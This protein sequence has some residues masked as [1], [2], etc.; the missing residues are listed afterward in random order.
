VWHIGY[1]RAYPGLI[2]EG[3]KIEKKLA[4][5][6]ANPIFLSKNT[7]FFQKLIFLKKNLSVR[8]AAAPLCPPGYAFDRYTYSVLIRN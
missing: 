8:G 6:G 4:G 1:T 2:L 7:K 5:G 3:S